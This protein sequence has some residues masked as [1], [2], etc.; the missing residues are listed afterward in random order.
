MTRTTIKWIADFALSVHR[1]NPGVAVR[2]LD[3]ATGKTV[4]SYVEPRLLITPLQLPCK[5][6]D[7]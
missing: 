6:L 1:H 5:A 7:Q 4:V 3:P 2:V